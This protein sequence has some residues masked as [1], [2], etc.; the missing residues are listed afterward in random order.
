MSRAAQLSLRQA[1]CWKGLLQQLRAKHASQ[2]LEQ[3]RGQTAQFALIQFL[4][5]AHD[6]QGGEL[7]PFPQHLC[8]AIGRNRHDVLQ[9]S[10][11]QVGN[12]L[13]EG[14]TAVIHHAHSLWRGVR[15]G[16]RP[17]H[18]LVGVMRL[19]KSGFHKE[20]TGAA[21]APRRKGYVHPSPTH[22]L[23]RPAS[24]VGR[25]PSTRE[26][27]VKTI[28]V[29]LE[30]DVM[31]L[32]TFVSQVESTSIVDQIRAAITVHLEQKV[33][34]GDLAERAEEAIAEIDREAKARKA[35]IGSLVGNLPKGNGGSAK[36]RTRR[37][38]TAAPEAHLAESRPIGYL[39]ALARRREALTAS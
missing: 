14:I 8:P 27:V 37:G 5:D 28:A 33:A 9:R 25:S 21:P 4:H 35:T 13:V 16:P 31:D 36:G 29:R 23:H 32:L 22:Q 7:V 2:T 10:S 3:V 15:D 20:T 18:T 30:D 39:P 17:Q 26:V 19:R 1:E 38:Q 34:S 6:L 12:E 24:P 11:Q